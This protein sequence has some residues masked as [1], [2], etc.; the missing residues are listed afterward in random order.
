MIA[1]EMEIPLELIRRERDEWE[2]KKRMLQITAQ[3]ARLEEDDESV[4][5][6]EREY[7]AAHARY[8]EA[9]RS[10]ITRG[11]KIC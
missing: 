1:Q 7:L 3:V 11:G 10:L 8:Q 4:K 6:F 5:W 9:C 2:R